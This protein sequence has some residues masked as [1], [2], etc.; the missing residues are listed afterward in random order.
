MA[1]DPIVA[2]YLAEVGHQMIEVAGAVQRQGLGIDLQDA[3]AL[4]A[5]PDAI[6]ICG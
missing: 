4:G 6:G 2:Q 3:D 1:L 5:A